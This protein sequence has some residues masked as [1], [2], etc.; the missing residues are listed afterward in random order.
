MWSDLRRSKYCL[1][2]LQEA[3]IQPIIEE[4]TVRYEVKQGKDV[5]EPPKMARGAKFMCIICGEAATPEYIKNEALSG[6]MNAVLIAVVAEGRNGRQY[7]SPSEIHVAAAMTEKPSDYPDGSMPTNPR[8]FTPPQY[9]FT[10]YSQLFTNR[11]LTAL[12]TFS[13]LLNSVTQQIIADG[14]SIEYA[15]AIN[16]YL[17]FAVDRS[18]DF[19]TSVSR[20]SVSNE[21]AMN[22]NQESKRQRE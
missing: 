21:K 12:V 9:G 14:G 1:R 20:W 4:K 5:P 3:Y 18:A 8:W 11:Q 7:L 10:D 16:V 15:K 2:I 22:A 13:E 19:S 6:R 17:A